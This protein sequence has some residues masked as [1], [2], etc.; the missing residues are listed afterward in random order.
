MASRL[1]RW[2]NLSYRW[3]NRYLSVRRGSK[4][5]LPTGQLKRLRSWLASKNSRET[6]EMS[7][8]TQEHLQEVFREDIRRLEGVIGRDLGHW[9]E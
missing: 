6:P 1:L 9:L 7:H 5:P 3:L 2:G 8:R 4:N